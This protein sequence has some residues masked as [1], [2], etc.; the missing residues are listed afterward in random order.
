MHFLSSGKGDTEL[1]LAPLKK[2][3]MPLLST[4]MR[5]NIEENPC[6]LYPFNYGED[7]FLSFAMDGRIHLMDPR[8]HTPILPWN[9]FIWIE[10]SGPPSLQAMNPLRLELYT[11]FVLL[12]WKGQ[13]TCGNKV[14]TVAERKFRIRGLKNKVVLEILTWSTLWLYFLKG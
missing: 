10:L 4:W 11:L 1:L 8:L 14:G 3:G 9:N 2:I 12:F 6:I 13:A 5:G 7:I